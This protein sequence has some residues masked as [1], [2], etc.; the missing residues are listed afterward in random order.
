MRSRQDYR[1]YDPHS[2]GLFPFYP[3]R[4]VK[5]TSNIPKT[6]NGLQKK[7]QAK[8]LTVEADHATR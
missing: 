6:Y 8:E 1:A 2:P 3:F 7:E 5:P 4:P